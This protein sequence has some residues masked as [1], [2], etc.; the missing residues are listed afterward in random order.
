MSETN[1]PNEWVLSE[2]EKT[3]AFDGL[4]S[5]GDWVESKDQ[6]PSG[7]VRLI[8]LADIGDGD[9]KNKSARFM[10]TER[11]NELNC[12]YLKKG[13]VLV[14][15]MPDPLGRACIFP[16]LDQDAVTVVDI[17]LIR[18]GKLSAINNI[19]LA[20]WVNSPAFRDLISSNASGTTRRRITRKK[21]EVFE[22]PIPP[23]AEQKEI[24][25]R[26]DKLL[27]QV[28]ATQVRL[29]RIP[30]IIKC[31]RQSVLAAAVNGKLTDEWRELNNGVD[32]WR[33]V[34]LK[35]AAEIIDPH[36]SHRTPKAVDGGV[37][38]IGIGDL[39]YDGSI[40]FENAR[41]V[42]FDVL[43]E[44]NERYTLKAGDFIFGKIGTLGKATV[45]PIGIDYTLSAN[46]I[47]IQPIEHIAT[48]EYLQ[49]FLSSPSTLNEIAKQANST[50]QAAFG[51][52]KMRTFQCKLPNKEEQNQIVRRVEQLFAYADTIE[53][54][55]KAA[56]ARVD[57]LTQA[58][59]AKA[60]RG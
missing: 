20:Y 7:V 38:Y 5:D 36:P 52:K 11:A 34:E 8:Q 29:A 59:L 9:F 46:V 49:F 41:K 26:L 1:L 10:T 44:H 54:Q 32:Q 22:L 30:D 21:L 57:N 18:T 42:S 50:S 13:D 31:F 55:A 12:T 19:L 40:D 43:K 37:P 14:A 51:I 25:D 48:P 53:Q 45:L 47:L 24:I 56:K 58:I 33:P 2:L 3:I 60:F 35:D 16:N 4:I 39:R 6:D 15:R 17:C 23:L 27:A 28:E